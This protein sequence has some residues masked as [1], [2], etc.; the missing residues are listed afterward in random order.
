MIVKVCGIT[1]Q[2]Q[3]NQLIELG[4][5]MIGLNF[6][7][8]SKRYITSPI[9]PNTTEASRVGIFVNPAIETLK[10]TVDQYQ[11]DIIQLHGD[12]SPEFCAT[13]SKIKPV[14]KAF[15]VDSQFSFDITTHYSQFAKYFL[16]DTKSVDYG[17]SGQKFN[18]SKLNEYDGSIPFL[19]SG[20]IRLEDIEEIMNIHHP[21]LSG[22]DVNSGFESSP[23][24]KDMDLIEQMMKLIKK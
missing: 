4:V 17:G 6:Y 24:I 11:L 20:G 14:I 23:G 10:N 3:Y 19:L 22:I 1:N 8:K 13:A 12:E 7:P 9:L 5:D 2:E 18:W 16:F 15:G 21:M